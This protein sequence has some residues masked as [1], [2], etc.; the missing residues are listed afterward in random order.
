[1]RYT[2]FRLSLGFRK[3]ALKEKFEYIADVEYY[4]PSK[5]LDGYTLSFFKRCRHLYFVVFC[6]FL[7]ENLWNSELFFDYF[8]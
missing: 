3:D 1:M 7:A 2:L 8:P 6:A 4:C 5:D